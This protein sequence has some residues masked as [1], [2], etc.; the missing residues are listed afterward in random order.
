MLSHLSRGE[1]V[2]D[3]KTGPC[4][5]PEVTETKFQLKPLAITRL[6]LFFFAANKKKINLIHWD[7]C[8]VY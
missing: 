7:R 6:L 2:K 8:L 5:S 4:G 3:P 1:I